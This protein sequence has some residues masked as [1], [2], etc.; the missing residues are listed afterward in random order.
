MLQTVKN[1][2]CCHSPARKAQQSYRKSAGACHHSKPCDE[3]VKNSSLFFAILENL[4]QI[5]PRLSKNPIPLGTD[6]H[7]PNLSSM[8]TQ[9]FPAWPRTFGSRAGR[10]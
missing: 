1:Y 5:E 7:D 6:S 3:S 8:Q 9:E 2:G 4:M 10:E